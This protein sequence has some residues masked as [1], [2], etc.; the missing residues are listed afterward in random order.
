MKKT[1][2]LI[3]ATL[4]LISLFISCSQNDGIE[5]AIDENLPEI[6]TK[7]SLLSIG[8]IDLEI[9]NFLEK[10]T[11]K[12]QE[13]PSNNLIIQ[14][15]KKDF[16]QN[17]NASENNCKHEVSPAPIVF[18][19]GSLIQ[20]QKYF[21]A[22][23]GSITD[24]DLEELLTSNSLTKKFIIETNQILTSLDTTYTVDQRILAENSIIPT[25][26]NSATL[27]LSLKSAITASM[28]YD[29]DFFYILEGSSLA[30][31][32]EVSGSKNSEDFDLDE[33]TPEIN[34]NL[35]IGFP[36]NNEDYHFTLKVDN[37]DLLAIEQ[38]QSDLTTEFNLLNS[39]NQ[40]VGTIKYNLGS[41]YEHFSLY[42]LDGNLIN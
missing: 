15:L 20:T 32:F 42:D 29:G 5:T 11:S 14:V 8:A 19:N 24:C 18:E 34:M 4:C 10:N 2:Y 6:S 21:N 30:I 35:N 27:K 13:N 39:K 37:M 12:K 26:L 25:S 17:F 22:E 16:I 31:K 1:P 28:D 41:S 23:G 33:I 36:V 9:P 3:A 7:L 40:K 38:N